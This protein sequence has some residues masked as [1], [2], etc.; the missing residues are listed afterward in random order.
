MTSKRNYPYY[1]FRQSNLSYKREKHCQK[2]C[3]IVYDQHH[4]QYFCIT[5]GTI[6]LQSNE[7]E[8]E[9]YSD[10]LFWQK[11]KEKR[12]KAKEEKEKAK[13]EKQKQKRLK[14]KNKNRTK[15]GVKK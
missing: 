10:P 12:E 2:N 7:Y 14:Q 8:T 11:L 6:I 15:K 3:D 13:T 5:C 9:Y 1:N 4:D